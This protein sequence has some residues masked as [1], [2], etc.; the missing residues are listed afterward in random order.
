MY[1][2]IAARWLPSTLWEPTRNWARATTSQCSCQ[3]NPTSNTQISWLTT[4]RPRTPPGRASTSAPALAKRAPC[5]RAS[6]CASSA[7]VSL[8]KIGRVSTKSTAKWASTNQVFICKHRSLYIH[9]I[10]VSY[11]L[12]TNTNMSYLTGRIQAIRTAAGHQ[13]GARLRMHSASRSRSLE[14]SF[15]A[16]ASVCRLVY[17]TVLPPYILERR[18]WREGHDI[19][20]VTDSLTPAKPVDL[21]TGIPTGA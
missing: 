1:N 5:T 7:S 4:L 9:N 11:T 18:T 15:S 3:R 16:S 13:S 14:L 17:T 2:L 10:C 6:S 12:Y 21:L 8:R 20:V 19:G